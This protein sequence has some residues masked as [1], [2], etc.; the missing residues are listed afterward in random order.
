MTDQGTTN[1]VLREQKML[2]QMSEFHRLLGSIHSLPNYEQQM[3][4][5]EIALTPQSRRINEPLVSWFNAERDE[6]EINETHANNTEKNENAKYIFVEQKKKQIWTSGIILIMLLI[7]ALEC[8][9]GNI[10]SISLNP[11]AGPLVTTLISFGAMYTPLVESGEWWRVLSAN[12]VPAGLIQLIIA[13]YCMLA[14]TRFESRY[15]FWWVCIIYSI[16][17]VYGQ[18]LSALALTN[19]V[20]CSCNGSL[21]GLIIIEIVY[22]IYDNISRKDKIKAYVKLGIGLL[23]I[24]IFGFLPMNDNFNTLGGI[25]MS[26]L[27]ILLSFP[28]T[29]KNILPQTANVIICTASFIIITL[30]WVFSILAITHRDAYSAYCSG[31]EKFACIDYEGWCDPVT[32]LIDI[33]S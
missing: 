26:I 18:I 25:V 30:A 9:Q 22:V 8:V 1:E 19:G 15:G 11:F 20:S 24:I 6:D 7:F 32:Q 12:V 2:L 4:D 10:V 27:L 5:E 3:F 28:I 23:L 14:L 16:C 31:C 33:S 13:A 29:A 21:A 17:G